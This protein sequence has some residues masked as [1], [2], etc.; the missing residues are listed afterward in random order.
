M[1]VEGKEYVYHIDHQIF[2]CPL[3]V[4]MNFIGGKWKAIILWYVH[5]HDGPIRFGEIKAFIPDITEKM[6]SLQLQALVQ[7]G[8]LLRTDHGGRP[9]KVD[10]Q[11]T[12]FGQT[13]VPILSEIRNW[14]AHQGEIIG[15]LEERGI[16]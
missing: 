2:H 10:Y 14:G 8:I 11:L 3:S 7:D 13:F 5:L 1:L 12:D 16:E 9:R 6:L 4:T 15:R